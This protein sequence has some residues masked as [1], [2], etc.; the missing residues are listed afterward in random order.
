M[1]AKTTNAKLLFST[2]E[3]QFMCCC[4][5][6]L[7]HTFPLLLVQRSLPILRIALTS[8]LIKYT[9]VLAMHIVVL[10]PSLLSWL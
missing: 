8:Y 6:F 3:C 2:S 1:S 4:Q 10:A 5:F 7:L 9:W